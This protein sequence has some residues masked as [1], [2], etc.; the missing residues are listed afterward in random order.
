[1]EK[2]VLFNILGFNSS[3]IMISLFKLIYKQENKY[4]YYDIL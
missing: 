4:M 1:M 3:I 2:K